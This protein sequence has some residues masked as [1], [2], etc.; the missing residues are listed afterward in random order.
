MDKLVT[1]RRSSKF[2]RKLRSSLIKTRSG[3]GVCGI[4]CECVR[5]YIGRTGRALAVQLHEHRN[6]LQQG[7]LE[8]SKLARRA[9]EE[10]HRIGWG[11]AR[12]LEIEINRRYR[13]C[14]ESAHMACVTSFSHLDS[15]N[16]PRGH[17]IREGQYDVTGSSWVSVRFESRVLS[18]LLHRWR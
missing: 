10:G 4:P 15:P 2:K 3:R 7:L 18:S 5:S 11:D 9:Y 16:Q 17:Q 14:K 12:V 13:K 8:I 1:L 6:N